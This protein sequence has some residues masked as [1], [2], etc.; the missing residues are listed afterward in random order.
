[1]SVNCG[2]GVEDIDFESD[3]NSECSNQSE[4]EEDG[5]L[6]DLECS[7]EGN[8][9]KQF[10]Q[11]CKSVPIFIKSLALKVKNDFR[12][13]SG[14]FNSVTVSGQYWIR[15]PCPVKKLEVNTFEISPSS[16]YSYDLFVWDPL[17]CFPTVKFHCADL[18]C[19]KDQLSLDGWQTTPV[20]RRVYSLNHSYFLMA[21]R[22]K[23][24]CGKR[25][26]STNSNFIYGMPAFLQDL[27][28]CQVTHRAAIDKGF[29]NFVYGLISEGCSPSRRRLVIKKMYFLNY[30]RLRMQYMGYVHDLVVTRQIDTRCSSAKAKRSIGEDVFELFSCL[31]RYLEG[32]FTKIIIVYR[33]GTHQRLLELVVEHIQ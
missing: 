7:V 3:S 11:K 15:R 16:F 30:D 17:T 32:L 1:V 12:N 6:E 8:E 19:S 29:L 31:L 22:Y 23:C 27:F 33:I 25:F 20:A 9:E 21:R 18:E 13:K 28:P 2:S 10:S 5:S 14:Y 26:M 4:D 24:V